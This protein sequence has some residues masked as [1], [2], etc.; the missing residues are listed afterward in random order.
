MIR[1][2]KTPLNKAVFFVVDMLRESWNPLHKWIYEAEE[3][4][5]GLNSVET[6]R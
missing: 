3:A 6:A 4:I 5:S 2:C 1:K